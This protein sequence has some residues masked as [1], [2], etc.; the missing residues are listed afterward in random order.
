MELWSPDRLL[1]ITP[2]TDSL[3]L[4]S[5]PV[6]DSE[7]LFSDKKGRAIPMVYTLYSKPVSYLLFQE[8]P[9]DTVF[10]NFR[11]LKLPLN[12][13][14]SHKDT[15]LIIPD[16]V[17]NTEPAY[18]TTSNTEAF[19]PFEGLNSSGS[20][21]RGVS[22]GNNQDAVL[23][24]SL[25]LQLSGD[26]GK[27]TEIRASITDNS[28]PV[29]ADGYTQ[30]LQEFDKVY[31]ELENAD[32]GLLR[33]GDYSMGSRKNP[34]LQFDKRI[35][36]A[37]IFT[38]IPAGKANVPLQL[39]G[40]IA[41]GKFARNRF[42]GEEGNQGPYKLRG[43]NG[44]QFIIIISGSERVY[45]DGVLMKRGEQYDYVID[46]NAGEITFTTLRPITKERRIVVEF[47]YTEQ[48]YLRTVAFGESGFESEN[49]K[50]TVQ[51]YNEQDSKNQPLLQDFSD[52]EK[53]ILTNA[54]DDFAKARSGTVKPSEF[55]NDLVLYELQDSLGYDSVLVYS[56]DSTAQLY[57]ASF[58]F[59]GA[60]Q[61]DYIL[62]QNNANGRVFRWLPPVNNIPQGN[63]APVKQ[64]IAPTQLQIVSLL[65]EGKIA[66]NHFINIS[67]ATSKN[68]VNLL[69]EL[70]KGDDRGAA[71]KL[72]YRW[73]NE[74]QTGELSAGVYYEFNDNNFTTVERIRNVEFSRDWN[75]PL[76]YNGGIQLAGADVSLT[77]DSNLISYR[78]D[79]LTINQY[80]GFKNTITG[81]IRNK[82]NVSMVTASW[83]TTDDSVG[84]TDFIR[85]EGY[86]THYLTPRIWTGIRSVG[87]W[88]LRKQNNTDTLR[89]SSYNFLQYQLYAGFGDT[90]QNFTEVNYLERWDDTANHG[91]FINYSRATSYGIRS[92][93]KTT[94]NSTINAQ[95]NVRNLKVYEPEE[96]ELE[97]TVTSRLSYLQRFFGNSITSNTFYES[98]SGTEPRRFFSY[99]E[100]PA[101]TGTYTF[102][103]YNGN[104]IKE[105]DEFEV[106]P[107]PDLARYVRVFQQSNQYLRTNLLKLG[108][109]LNIN[110][111]ASWKSKDDVRSLLH[112]LSLLM[113]YQLD[114][115]TLLTGNRNNLN[116]F[117]KPK[118]DSLIV[119]LNNNFRSTLFFN[120][121]ATYFGADYT[122]R[123]TDNRNLLSFGVEQRST[124]ENSVNLR[125]QPIEVLILKIN[126]AIIEKNNISANFS[127][128]NFSID[129]LQN[130][131]ALSYQPGN[132]LVLTARYEVDN[133]E[134][135]GEVN[136][137]LKAQTI[138]MDIGYNSAERLSAQASLNY[139]R[140]NFSGT[141]NSPAGYEML[142]A[143][144]PGDNGTWTL[145]LQRTL[146]KNILISLN[147]SGRVSPDIKPIHTGNL[148]I[149]AFF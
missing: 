17:P 11:V 67:L 64:L 96:K 12:Q 109:N 103:D 99:L 24:S 3:F 107:T 95:V 52:E 129:Q 55:Q 86:F 132:H 133:Q 75:L 8:P 94:F 111:P 127:T 144:Q 108:Q 13:R 36:G 85:E 29:Q 14:F 53:A 110:S 62:E 5:L 118:D 139:I 81:G 84:S 143:L 106:A 82:S 37:G 9:S 20:I 101:G 120:R 38:N 122:Y 79:L 43:N 137:Q 138:G 68:D 145:T 19:K 2:G 63:Y 104:G 117:A 141:Q 102:T 113:N 114:R 112:R 32:F 41:R 48:N 126:G 59:V 135:F 142:Q 134:S 44:E 78:A 57:Q 27:G 89:Q 116:P 77:T 90:S 71:G 76:N 39:Q 47:Q 148:E 70:D 73:K 33:A 6:L 130:K 98:G 87:E 72:G 146:K 97:Q 35:S 16:I 40:G 100:V 121:S 93:Y 34:F 61:G 56:T 58:T 131:Y 31:I 66:E 92:R 147:Y 26:L 30:Q 91:R 128:R 15:T 1:L 22:V 136:N 149:K 88:N 125:L 140:N 65:S 46:Y 10:V 45:I 23:N 54:G 25:N 49:F 50:T 80:R 115:K 18:Q 69:S 123:Q 83:L 74:L 7:I 119:A 4:D 28:L 21:S 124:V 60:N 105:L 42:Q 51:F